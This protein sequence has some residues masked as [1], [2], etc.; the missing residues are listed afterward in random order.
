MKRMARA[1]GT[2]EPMA[3]VRRRMT[4]TTAAAVRTK[5]AMFVLADML[6]HRCTQFNKMNK[7]TRMKDRNNS[8]NKNKNKNS[9]KKQNER[10]ESER[11]E[12]SDG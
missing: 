4:A 3:L 8:K 12:R 11:K 9:K 2:S 7:A 10:N 6:I 5:S 1:T